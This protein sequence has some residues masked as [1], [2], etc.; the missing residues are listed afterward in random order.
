MRYVW[1]VVSLGLVA[2]C[3]GSGFV[4]EDDTRDGG[5]DSGSGGNDS[6][7][8]P[9]A[10]GANLDACGP[11]DTCTALPKGCCTPCGAV[12]ASMF[13]AVNAKKV[14]DATKSCAGVACPN[15]LGFD[16]ANIAARCVAGRCQVFDVRKDPAI[17][18]CA[19]ISDCTLRF[20]SGC[21]ES[22]SQDT[23]IAVSVKGQTTLTSQVCPA[24]GTRPP[25]PG[26]APRPDP[27]TKAA[28]VQGTC[29]VVRAR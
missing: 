5:K 29:T 24:D 17:S 1:L 19:D 26:C 22:C 15:C 20:G 12:D 6:G 7:T 4:I 11:S 10:P 9:D 23:V 27:N 28:C 3:S 14:S 16:H 25:C 8:V 18:G 2:A 13:Y 21:C